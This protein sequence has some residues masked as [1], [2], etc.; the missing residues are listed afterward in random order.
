MTNESSVSISAD[1]ELRFVDP[2]RVNT[3]DESALGDS[4]KPFEKI[5]Q[6][7][8]SISH[9]KGAGTNLLRDT[10]SHPFPIQIS[11]CYFV[12][13]QISKI[14]PPFASQLS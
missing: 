10:S 5:K 14:G 7:H 1:R 8:G 9:H 3:G 4:H 12:L 6:I 11:L 2:K 13:N